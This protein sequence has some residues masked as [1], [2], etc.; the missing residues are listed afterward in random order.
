MTSLRY[1]WVLLDADGT[2]LD[3]RRAETSALQTAPA[4]LGIDVPDTF[5]ATYHR[6]N[7]RLWRAFENGELQARDVREQRFRLVLDKLRI[8]A[9]PH[10]LSETF[11]AHLVRESTCMNGARSLLAALR[12]KV[13]T[14][15]LTNGF[16]DVQRARLQRL[17]LERTF[18]HVLISED[19][20][21]AKPARAIFDLAFERM[22]TSSKDEVLIVGD[23]LSSDIRGGIDYGIDTCWFNPQH[24][25]NPVN[26]CPTYEMSHLKELLPI[27]RAQESPDG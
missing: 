14:V 12:G 2:L 13:G 17:N 3:F 4:S 11:L 9:E 5:Q 10:V 22:G 15:L 6:V 16:A 26:V 21:V 20:G 23:S 24:E 27:L 1:R 25:A 8:D 19:V 18:D 7:D